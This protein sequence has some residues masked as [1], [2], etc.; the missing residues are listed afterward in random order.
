MRDTI[1]KNYRKGWINNDLHKITCK[2][3]FRVWKYAYRYVISKKKKVWFFKNSDI[4]LNFAVNIIIF[5]SWNSPG[6]YSGNRAKFI[7]HCQ[8]RVQIFM[9]SSLYDR[10][11][12]WRVTIM[13]LTPDSEA[14]DQCR[15]DAPWCFG[16]VNST[17]TMSSSCEGFKEPI[18]TRCCEDSSL[19]LT[20]SS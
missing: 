10:R 16:S 5:I 17:L 9:S 14:L 20:L 15:V 3:Y 19:P 2:A 4:C 12:N 13:S 1:W 6:I 11:A 18:S 7:T 8:N